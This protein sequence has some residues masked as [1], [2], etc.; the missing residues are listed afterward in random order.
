MAELLIASI[1]FVML[2]IAGRLLGRMT[3][4]SKARSMVAVR[5]LTGENLAVILATVAIIVLLI[6]GAAVAGPTLTHRQLLSA[7]VALSLAALAGL[8]IFPR[9]TLAV[10]ALGGLLAELWMAFVTHGPAI[11]LMLIAWALVMLWLLGLIRGFFR[12]F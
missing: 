6:D 12:P 4:F 3:P 7:M 8:A 9:L 11:G 1:P 10:V 2:L 5:S